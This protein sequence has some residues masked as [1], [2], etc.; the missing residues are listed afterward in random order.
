[1]LNLTVDRLLF[2]ISILMTLVMIYTYVQCARLVRSVQEK[3]DQLEQVRRKL[4][5][6]EADFGEKFETT[7]NRISSRLAM[8]E[9]REKS[10]RGSYEAEDLNSKPNGGII[11]YGPT[12]R[13]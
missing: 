11:T 4:L 6:L 9:K 2:C 13:H 5:E 7:M 3:N 1:M 8:R 12:Q 10:M